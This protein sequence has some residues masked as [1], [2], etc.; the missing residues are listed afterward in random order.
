[1]GCTMSRRHPGGALNPPDPYDAIAPH[2]R[3]R[4][5]CEHARVNIT[6]DR[7]NLNIN[8]AE[9]TKRSDEY[10]SCCQ[11]DDRRIG[12]RRGGTLPV[13]DAPKEMRLVPKDGSPGTYTSLTYYRATCPEPGCPRS[14]KWRW[15]LFDDVM[16]ALYRHRTELGL[17]RR[18]QMDLRVFAALPARL[19]VS[20]R[21]E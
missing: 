20:H 3:L 11:V 18:A 10:S 8:K 14:V 9:T 12:G 21:Q 15:P 7:I 1:M 6:V 4:V 17:E 16:Q 19:G 2:W 13:E 5:Y